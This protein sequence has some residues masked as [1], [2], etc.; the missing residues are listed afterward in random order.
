MSAPAG[1]LRIR[2]QAMKPSTS[3]IIKSR[4]TRS[5]RSFSTNATPSFPPA[6]TCTSKPAVPSSVCRYARFGASSSMTAMRDV[7]RV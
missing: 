5:G 7:T 1:P 6:A 4:S 3:G 2:S